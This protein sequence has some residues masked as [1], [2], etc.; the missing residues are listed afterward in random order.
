MAVHTLRFTQLNYSTIDVA[1]YVWKSM[2]RIMSGRG[3]VDCP[4][5]IS[6]LTSSLTGLPV[7]ASYG[8]GSTT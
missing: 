1:E 3:F 6:S 5:Q 4:N 7:C 2:R 8:G